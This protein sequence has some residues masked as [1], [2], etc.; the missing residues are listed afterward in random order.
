MSH[1]E[2]N[3]KKRRSISTSYY[4]Q[5]N[6]SGSFYNIVA[7]PHNELIIFNRYVDIN[8]HTLDYVQVYVD[9]VHCVNV[10]LLN[11]MCICVSI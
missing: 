9:F 8:W 4:L 3:R 11:I 1:F 2:D 6:A 5:D 7:C 10:D